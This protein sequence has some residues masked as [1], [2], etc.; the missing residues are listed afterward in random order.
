MVRN[1]WGSALSRPHARHA[2][3][4]LEIEWASRGERRAGLAYVT[5]PPAMVTVGEAPRLSTK[6]A[7]IGLF[8]ERRGVTQ[9]DV[10]AA[11]A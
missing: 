1:G 7:E 4:T 3:R 9:H 11:A 10:G 6:R 5:L 2:A 8:L